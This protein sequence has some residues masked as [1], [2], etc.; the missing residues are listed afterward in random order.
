MA[1]RLSLSQVDA[2][3]R[4]IG[5]DPVDVRSAPLDKTLLTRLQLAHSMTVPY[6]NTRVHLKDVSATAPD[7]PVLWRCVYARQAL[8][9]APDLVLARSSMFRAASISSSRSAA[10]AVVFR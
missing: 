10:A 4:R 3:L 1:T 7:E 9:D 5:L 2:Y 6:D 8:A